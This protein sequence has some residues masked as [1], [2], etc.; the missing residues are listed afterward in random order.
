MISKKVSAAAL[1]SLLLAGTAVAADAPAC[2]TVR[3]F[4]PGWT[5]ISSTNAI[6]TAL[7]DG[8]GYKADIRTLSVPIGYKAI[9][10]KEID[11]FLGNWMPAQQRFIDTLNAA[12]AA[13]KLK[14][15][16][17]DA[18]FTLAVPTYVADAGVHDFKDLAA[19]ADKFEK[20]IYGIEAGAPANQSLQ[21]MIKADD[22]GLKDWQVVESG[23]QAMLSQV[24]R[25]EKQKS[26][27][28][29]L[30][31]APHPMNTKLKLTYLSGGDTYFGP[32]YGGATV[33]TIART[34]WADACP[35]AA[36]LFKQLSFTLDIEN[37]MMGKIMDE[38]KTPTDAAKAYLK[39]N[40]GLIEPWLKGVTTLDGK[41]GLPAVK[42]ALGL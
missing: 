36:M 2:K 21:K 3:M 10:N 42:S 27:I 25:A 5:D 30:G 20:K 18:K 14:E 35:N 34:G 8:L 37:A 4:D 24:A 22:F 41:P 13:E 7:L 16:L 9:E 15:N 19:H 1:V 26:W 17:P 11:V 12:K 38:G 6:A 39:A 40:A 32:N 33:N 29:F 31:W 23:E 28:V